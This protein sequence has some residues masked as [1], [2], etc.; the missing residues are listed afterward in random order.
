M[1]GEGIPDLLMLLIQL[2]QKLISDKLLKLSTL[3]C[4][5]LE[6]RSVCDEE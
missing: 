4:T 6:V 2:S 1:T 3:Q 5:V